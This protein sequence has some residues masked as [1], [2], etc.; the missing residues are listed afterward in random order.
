L[1]SGGPSRSRAAGRRFLEPA[2]RYRSRCDRPRGTEPVA[3]GPVLAHAAPLMSA[4]RSKAC[5]HVCRTMYAARFGAGASENVHPMRRSER[6]QP[7]LGEA[8]R[9]LREKRGATQEAVARNAGVTTATLSLI[10][11]GQANPTWDTVTKIAAAL[12]ASIGELGSM[13]DKLR[14]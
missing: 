1:W 10:E 6:P 8:V 13:V 5:V 7:A 12:G 9:Q 4:E 11:R 14:N 3:T 2:R